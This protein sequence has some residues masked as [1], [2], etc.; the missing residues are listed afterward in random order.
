MLK[1]TEDLRPESW[2]YSILG[3]QYFGATVSQPFFP[4]LTMPLAPLI[5]SLWFKL[6]P[7]F[8]KLGILS[9]IWLKFRNFE[10]S[11]RFCYEPLI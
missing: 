2:G 1:H 6:P 4:R 9:V 11:V 8:R 3:L 7:L 10:R 5:L